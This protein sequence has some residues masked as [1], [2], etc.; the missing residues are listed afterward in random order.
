[1]AIGKKT[2]CLI[3]AGALY[4]AAAQFPVRH[5]HLH[6]GCGGTLTVDENGVAFAG[7]KG[8]AWKWRLE[9]IQELK[10]APDSVT[11]LT[12]QDNKWRPGTDREYRFIGTV[13]ARELYA[14]LRPR[15]DQ[16][17]VAE[18]AEPVQD[19]AWSLPVKHIGRM[20]GSQGT[21]A[22]G[23]ETIVYT[24]AAR[25]DS[26]TWRYGDID[27]IGSSGPFQLT[28]TTFERNRAQYADRRGFNFVLKQPITE[29]KYNEL[30]L[31]IEKKNGR[32]P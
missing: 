24:T 14:L 7:P 27:S 29:A 20:A 2:G 4:A 15:M 16:R 22:F 32:I 18:I 28:I 1:M 9:D 30:W 17:L 11:V 26:R 8:H 25:D 13:P 12:Y 5:P 21:L 10:L 31:R 19:A 3:L 23:E 6:G